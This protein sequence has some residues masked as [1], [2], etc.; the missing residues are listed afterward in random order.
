MREPDTTVVYTF[1]NADGQEIVLKRDVPTNHVV[2]AYN[3]LVLLAEKIVGTS[4]DE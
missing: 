2:D 3:E 4:D 1:K